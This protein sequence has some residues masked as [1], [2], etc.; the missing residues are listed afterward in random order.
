M[1]L[2]ITAEARFCRYLF[3]KIANRGCI[4]GSLS[5]NERMGNTNRWF[6]G[7]TMKSRNTMDLTTGS[8][9][10][11]L[12]AFMLPLLAS[13]LLQ[14]FYNAADKAVVG[15][16]AGRIALA[17]VGSTNSATTM[18]L[19]LLVGL[20]AGASI[21]NANLL[22][23]R[24]QD[25]LRR[26]MHT[27]IVVSGICGLFIGV[28]GIVACKPLLRLMSCP[29]SVIDSAALYMRIYFCGVPA[30]MLYNFGAGILRTH[31]DTKR[32]MFILAISGLVNVVL[33][34][35]FV[36]VFKMDVD[37]VAYATIISQY[38][39][40]AWVLYILFAPKGDYRLRIKE[41]KLHKQE[42][43]AIV[44]VGLPCGV[45][46][47]VFSVSNV[48]VQSTI[49]GFGDVVIAGSVASDSVTGFLY[50]ILAAFYTSCVTYAGQCYGAKKMK[51]INKLFLSAAGISSSIM[52]ILAIVA[53]F[54]P[55][56][57]LGIFNSEPDVVA[58]G[59]QKMMIMCWSYVLYAVSEVLLG[60]LRGMRKGTIPTTIN[61][62]GICMTRVLWILF[63]FP[64][65]SANI[66]FLYLCY[67][68]SYVISVSAMVIYYTYCYR[69]ET[70]QMYSVSA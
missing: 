48:I 24:K 68:L 56:T 21:I 66:L 26:S 54:T 40:S 67:P 27:S 9:T 49:N 52:V 60:C 31:G 3:I 46:G 37:G 30:S 65:N 18:M 57:L 16:F 35:L 5:Y 55:K 29:D 11:K 64:M 59:A 41:L 69:R 32:P 38:I 39:S 13:N 36:I 19:N 58:A 33:N 61:I 20:S 12:I 51:R 22:G 1:K 47:L 63:V 70:K 17:A 7:D 43:A 10:R 15:Q 45:N 42:A 4:L 6:G 28:F 62:A 2:E 14:Y 34:L 53:S 8:V 23:A 44:K 25:E 50:Q